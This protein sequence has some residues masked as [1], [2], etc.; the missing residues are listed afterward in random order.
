MGPSSTMK[1][2]LFKREI[3]NQL[4]MPSSS[5]TFTIKMNQKSF[6]YLSIS[7]EVVKNAVSLKSEIDIQCYYD[8][9]PYLNVKYLSPSS[10]L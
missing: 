2:S 9:V 10:L 6:P 4:S 5:Q 1:Q 8:A 3:H 7:N